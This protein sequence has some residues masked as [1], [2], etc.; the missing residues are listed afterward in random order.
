MADATIYFPPKTS[1]FGEGS[2]PR[3]WI[4]YEGFEPMY[5]IK[6]H[7]QWW[8]L[9]LSR[10]NLRL[11]APQNIQEGNSQQY[12]NVSHGLFTHGADIVEGVDL[13]GNVFKDISEFG[14][15]VGEVVSR[16]AGGAFRGFEQGRIAEMLV[17]GTVVNPRENQHF[18]T[19]QFRTFSHNWEMFAINEGDEKLINSVIS[20]FRKYALPSVS[21]I[22]ETYVTTYKAPLMW[23]IKHLFQDESGNVEDETNWGNF[24]VSVIT[25]VNVNYTGAGLYAATE[26]GPAFVNL[27]V[28]FT[29]V[30]LRNRG[31]EGGNGAVARGV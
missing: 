8:N 23:K 4:E 27:T 11:I 30:K 16:L 29:E 2:A 18:K 12:Q 13:S 25:D 28:N 1:P 14:A 22:E 15:Q 19:P 31:D 10:V 20:N 5:D 26:A 21:D 6:T 24:G 17:R 7:S 9:G 3:H